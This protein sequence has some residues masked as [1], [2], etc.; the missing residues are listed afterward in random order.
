MV[1]YNNEIGLLPQEKENLRENRSEVS[2]LYTSEK[3]QENEQ[4]LKKQIK[5]PKL[6]S[7]QFQHHLNADP[8]LKAAYSEHQALIERQKRAIERVKNT[9]YLGTVW[10]GI[11]GDSGVD[12]LA[13]INEGMNRENTKF[14]NALEENS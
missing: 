1:T 3:N 14:R 12:D 10:G 13:R 7:E 5:K 6:T 11:T 9:G 8:K 4:A 2:S